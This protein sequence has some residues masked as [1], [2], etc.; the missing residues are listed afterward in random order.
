MAE[1]G[2]GRPVDERSFFAC[3][4][5]RVTMTAYLIGESYSRLR[6]RAIRLLPE[7][8]EWWNSSRDPRRSGGTVHRG[9]PHRGRRIDKQAAEELPDP[10]DTTLFRHHEGT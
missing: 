7:W 8:A 3:S 2:A 6:N 9:R 1:W 4:P 10:V 5:F